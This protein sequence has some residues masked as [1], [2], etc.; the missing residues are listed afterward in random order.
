MSAS[1]ITE[2]QNL[3]LPDESYQSPH[4]VRRSIVTNSQVDQ[5]STVNELSQ[6]QYPNTIW[7]RFIEKHRFGKEILVGAGMTGVFIIMFIVLGTLGVFK[8]A[9][10]RGLAGIPSV[11]TTKYNGDSW[12]TS[13]PGH[14]DMGG[15]GDGTYY[16]K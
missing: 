8:N 13:T 16:G 2:Q 11:G 4:L 5:S 3:S 1:V 12:G 7:T 6:Q 15:K 9:E 10:Y 14:F